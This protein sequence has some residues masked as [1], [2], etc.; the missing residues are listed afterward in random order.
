M[1][2]GA[3]GAGEGDAQPLEVLCSEAVPDGL[4]SLD[5][6]MSLL[7]QQEIIISK[8]NLNFMVSLG[9]FSSSEIV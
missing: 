1:W 5:P 8:C 2:K 4:R 6:T 9:S 3:P 7:G